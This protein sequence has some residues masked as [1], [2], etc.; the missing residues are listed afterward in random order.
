MTQGQ[1]VCD[2][3]STL[4][5]PEIAA[6]STQ[7]TSR[8]WVIACRCGEYHEVIDSVDRANHFV[9]ALP[10]T[11][12]TDE[13]HSFSEAD[14]Q[15][16]ISLC[17]QAVNCSDQEAILISSYLEWGYAVQL[18]RSDGD[19]AIDVIAIHKSCARNGANF[20][21]IRN[22]TYDAM[23]GLA[24]QT[25]FQ[26]AFQVAG[27]WNP[28]PN[29]PPASDQA[30]DVS[31]DSD[32]DKDHGEDNVAS[33]D[34]PTPP[35]PAASDAEAAAEPTDSLDEGAIAMEAAESDSDSILSDEPHELSAPVDPSDA[36]VLKWGMS[37]TDK[38]RELLDGYGAATESDVRNIIALE[39]L[40]ELRRQYHGTYC[41]L[42]SSLKCICIYVYTY[43]Y[44]C[45]YIYKVLCIRMQY[46]YDAITYAGI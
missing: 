34:G 17:L 4:C 15:N 13:G 25:W 16:H 36:V 24:D 3:F 26:Q 8:I 28:P 29:A 31:D 42:H 19:C 1:N 40:I 21:S 37:R 35:L 5:T 7:W 32:E 41:V 9:Y 6:Q 30:S 46:F 2:L 22:T 39:E 14:F 11:E 10:M 12:T 44:C 38:G 18:T 27:E 33:G 43:V 45:G 20:I 23:I